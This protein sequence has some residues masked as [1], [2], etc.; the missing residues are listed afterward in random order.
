MGTTQGKH[1]AMS[2]PLFANL[3]LQARKLGVLA[4]VYHGEAVAVKPEEHSMNLFRA[5]TFK[6]AMACIKHSMAC[7]KHSFTQFRYSLVE[8]DIIGLILI[9]LSLALILVPL[10]LT[11]SG[12]SSWSSASVIAMLVMG[13]VCLGITIVYEGWFAKYPAVPGRFMK[14]PTVLAACIIN[15]FDFIS[16]YLQFTYQCE[17]T[18][19]SLL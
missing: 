11:N 13:F 15:L 3:R 1:R 19:L 2:N 10:T 7:I 4:T 12:D 14:N 6:H 8:I 9:G 5:R 17:F 18:V 16:F